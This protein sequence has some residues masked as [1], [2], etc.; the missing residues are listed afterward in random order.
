MVKLTKIYTRGGDKGQTSL[1]DGSRV[2]KNDLRVTAYGD[3]D[4]T[5]SVVG[6]ARLHSEGVMDQMLGRI[7]NDLF[8]LGADLSTPIS[9]NPKYPPL[10][11][12]ESQVTRLEQEIDALNSSLSELRSFILPGGRA[13]SAY[14]HH[15]RTVSRRAERHV[16]AL[17]KDAEV[18]PLAVQYIN[19]L[20]DFFF[21]AARHMNADGAD[22]VLWTPGENR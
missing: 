14:L 15:A 8:D 6:L 12:V 9:E 2:D 7:Q 13:A 21:V 11:I 3:V 19:R 4:E 17:A 22:D 16:V 1:S 20:S 5:N 10:R 18:N